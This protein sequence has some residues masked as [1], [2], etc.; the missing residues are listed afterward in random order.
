MNL[1][2]LRRVIAFGAKSSNGYMF[3][4]ILQAMND[5]TVL[6]ASAITINALSAGTNDI[7]TETGVTLTAA[8]TSTTS[9]PTFATKSITYNLV[10]ST[11]SDVYYQLADQSISVIESSTSSSTPDLPCSSSGST[12]ITYTTG[13]Y[14][15]TAVPS[16]VSINSNTGAL[17]ILTPVVNTDTE[18]NFYINSVITGSPGPSQKKI[19]LTVMN[20]AISNC[21]TCTASSV[22]ICQI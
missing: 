18:Y 21:E 2:I 16:W 1:L 11:K 7:V 13:N 14:G 3:R 20:C 19:K 6:A 22:S 12:T 8:S 10:S 9:I 15:S 17:S 5:V 4:F